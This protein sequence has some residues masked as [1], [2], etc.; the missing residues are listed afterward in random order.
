M[1]ID[2]SFL[3]RWDM[4]VHHPEGDFPSWFELNA[5]GTGRFVGQFGSARP[6]AK[7]K[8]KDGTL[9]FSLPKQYEPRDDDMVFE[10][11]LDGEKLEGHTTHSDAT[12]MS[13]TAVK[14]PALPYR[15]TQWGTPLSLIQTDLA[16]WEPR[17]PNWEVN[18][19]IENGCLVNTKVGSDLILNE[20]YGDFKLVCEY[21]YPAGSNSGIYL[22]GRYEVQILDDFGQKPSWGSSAGV[23]GFLVPLKNA[24][25]AS[26]EW[27]TIEIELVG[28]WVTITLNGQTVVNKKE[29]PGITGGALESNEG[30]PGRTF[31]QGDHGPITFRKVEITPSVN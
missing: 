12:P 18:W 8:A 3:G 20:A 11:R 19:K 13:W 21:K 28:R 6:I 16:N 29:I 26:D 30:A 14:A 1:R 17:S 25:N 2:A 9:T 23:Y 15:E 7:S 24:I 22:R 31:L 10:G 5:D 27:N 4:T